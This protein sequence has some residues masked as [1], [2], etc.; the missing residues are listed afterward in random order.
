MRRTTIL[1]LAA[2][3]L[4]IPKLSA[5]HPPHVMVDSVWSHLGGR[6][7]FEK[8]RYV[9][10]TWAYEQEGTIVVSRDHTWDRY[11]GAYV[12]AMKDRKTGDAI[13]VFF[14]VDTKKGTAL[15]NGTP[16]EGKEADEVLER[17]YGVFINDTYWLLAPTK[18]ED[19]GARLRFDTH[20]EVES[21]GELP[22]LHLSFDNVGL[23]PGDQYWLYTTNDGQ[24]VK[25]RYKL[26]G[27]SE[28]EYLWQDERDCGMGLRF[29]SRKASLDGKKAIVFPV[30]EFMETMDRAVFEAATGR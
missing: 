15:R 25:W 5:S 23:T 16:L 1:T 21:F 10:F 26:E 24:V 18:L 6:E 30:I 19:Y 13:K 12:L 14:N 27:G 28:G 7:T 22:V 8:A 20:E 9:R 17:A 4:L 11:Q 2:I 29:C 3:A